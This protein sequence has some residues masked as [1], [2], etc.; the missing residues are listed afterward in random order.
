M[1]TFQRWGYSL[2]DMLV[3]NLGD[4][5]EKQLKELLKRNNDLFKPTPGRTAVVEHSIHV[6][7]AIPIRQK[8]YRIPYSRRKVVEKEIQ[9]MLDAG[10]VR[11]SNSPWASPIVLVEKKDGVFAFVLTTEN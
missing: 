6:E 8:P 9:K 3:P 11:R 10:V 7:D 5:E 2:Q 1:G 4:K